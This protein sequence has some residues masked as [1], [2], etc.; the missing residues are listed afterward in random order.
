MRPSAG[1]KDKTLVG[2]RKKDGNEDEEGGSGG[3]SGEVV[4]VE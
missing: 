2:E 4:L 1:L 3:R